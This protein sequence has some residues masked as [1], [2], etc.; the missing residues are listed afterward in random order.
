MR[1][2]VREKMFSI[3]GDFWI[4]DQDDNRVFLVDGKAV[5]L[6][7]TV[8]LKD[9][10]GNIVATV[11]KKLMALR[12]TMEID[13]DGAPAA[14]V[15]KMMISPLRHRSVVDLADGGQLEAAGDILGKEFEISDGQRTMARISRS[16]FRIRDTYGVD[17]APG[18]DDVLLL[19]VAVALDRI[20]R[21]EE[22]RRDR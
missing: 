6:R 10:G 1:Y 15:R 7:E 8:E 19:A 9:S 22:R 5:S 14:T 11:R 12:E 3:G 16:W 18:E 21:D 17:V 13:R 20:H 4:T 2:A